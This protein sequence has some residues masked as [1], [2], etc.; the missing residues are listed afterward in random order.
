MNTLVLNTLGK[1]V[2]E[3]FFPQD[4]QDKLA[5]VGE[6]HCVSLEPGEELST[7]F[8]KLAEKTEV[9]FTGWGVPCL[10]EDL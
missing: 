2:F 1:E 7:E 10:N 8:L 9:L 5:E 6:V 3:T 4:V